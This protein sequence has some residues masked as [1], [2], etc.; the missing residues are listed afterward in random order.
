MLKKIETKS[1]NAPDSQGDITSAFL[2]NNDDER[3]HWMLPACDVA[4]FSLDVLER[5]TRDLDSHGVQI[6]CRNVAL[7]PETLKLK[8][9]VECFTADS[10]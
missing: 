2:A 10:Q 4:D 3:L 5:L 1:A 8:I 9:K 6:V 7:L